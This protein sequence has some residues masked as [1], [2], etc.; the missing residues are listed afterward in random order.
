MIE[1]TT[2]FDVKHQFLPGVRT[3]FIYPDFGSCR[4]PRGLGISVLVPCPLKDSL[5]CDVLSRPVLAVQSS[6]IGCPYIGDVE[7]YFICENL[8]EASA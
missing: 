1:D 5:S 8:R 2:T 7:R 3:Q 4:V 6:C